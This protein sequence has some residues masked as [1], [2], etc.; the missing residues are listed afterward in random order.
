[1]HVAATG[2]FPFSHSHTAPSISSRGGSLQRSTG[3]RS[4]SGLVRWDLSAYAIASELARLLSASKRRSLAVESSADSLP[5]QT[6]PTAMAMFGG[7]LSDLRAHYMTVPL[8]DLP[9]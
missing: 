8:R 1:M 7:V 2:R 4:N 3:A 6:R 5:D 9:Q